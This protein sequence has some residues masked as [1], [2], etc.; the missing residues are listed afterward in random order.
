MEG[1]TS[2]NRGNP[3]LVVLQLMRILS[4]FQDPGIFGH[5]RI[6]RISWVRLS[7]AGLAFYLVCS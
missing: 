5:N 2:P 3:R 6:N 1:N 7:D 4:V